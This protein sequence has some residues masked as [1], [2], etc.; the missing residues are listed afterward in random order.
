MNLWQNP[1]IELFGLRIDEPIT[2]LTDLI[3]AAVG[4]IGYYKT[5]SHENTRQISLYRYFFLLTAIST[6]IAAFVGHA[7]GYHFGTE[8]RMIGWVIGIGGVAFAQFAVLYNT[9]NSIGKT[10]F[11]A[12]FFFNVAELA[13][14]VVMFIIYRSFIIVEIH[15]AFGLVLM[16]SVLEAVH[17][18]K[19]KSH[20][21]RNMMA[22]VGLAIAAVICHIAELA[23]GIWFNHLDLSH[24]LMAT[25]LYVMYKG[26]LS[27]Q[28]LNPAIV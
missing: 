15:S 8:K 1:S 6:L 24:L 12:L 2:T 23:F 27:E 13:T 4:F 19:T 10:L 11:R 7:F 17:Y 21:S 3:V 5:I 18:A 25:A 26:I 28:K 16:V 14:T 9:R 22:G 20:L